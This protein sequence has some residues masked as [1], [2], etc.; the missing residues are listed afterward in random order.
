MNAAAAPPVVETA[1][2]SA[3]DSREVWELLGA[4]H[5]LR[6]HLWLGV[7]GE[8]SMGLS[9]IL[10][11]DPA[12]DRFVID[13][14]RQA[15]GLI[16]DSPVYFD[17]QVEGR[18]LRFECRLSRFLNYDNAPAYLLCQPRLVL[19][20]QRRSA[21]RVR[22]PL[23][24]RIPAA[25]GDDGRMVPARLLDLSTQ[26]CSTRSETLLRLDRG[27]PVR[28]RLKLGAFDL[29][30]TARIRNVQ[31]IGGASR[32]GME[33]ELDEAVESSALEQA[34]A[35]LQREILRRRQN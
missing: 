3:H 15:E 32:V 19:D 5:L 2:E 13:A 10:A 11:I 18:R 1:P 9:V 20:Q 6:A 23:D 33:F 14:L 12:R 8:P 28:M 4:L 16:E 24:L 22:V 31:R 21:Y 26:G 35:R 27:D 34:V 30:C 17:T 7:G 29:A 25:L